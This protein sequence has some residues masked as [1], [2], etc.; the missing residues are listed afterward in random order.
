MGALTHAGT[1][2]R[3]VEPRGGVALRALEHGCDVTIAELDEYLA[4]CPTAS[5][6]GVV[7]SGVVDRLPLHAMIPLLGRCRQSLAPG[8][9]LVVV[10]EAPAPADGRAGDPPVHDL[11]DGRSLHAQTWGLLLERSGFVDV[12]DVAGPDDGEDH[13]YGISARTPIS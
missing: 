4:A 7:L 6:G 5:L 1:P 2:A 3:G 13:R 12:E 10:A 9:P 8:A 11:V